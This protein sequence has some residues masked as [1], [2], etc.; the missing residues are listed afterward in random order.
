M[1]EREEGLDRHLPGCRGVADAADWDAV[2]AAESLQCATERRSSLEDALVIPTVA[3]TLFGMLLEDG[4]EVD[5]TKD[6]SADGR[7]GVENE[8]TLSTPLTGGPQ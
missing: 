4:R 6:R 2:L 1:A 5:S 7:K 3:S 8:K